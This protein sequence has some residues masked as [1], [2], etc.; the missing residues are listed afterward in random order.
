MRGFPKNF[1][2]KTDVYNSLAEFPKETKKEVQRLLDTR[3]VWVN[4]AVL[5]PAVDVGVVDDNH[6]IV[7][8]E[9]G[10]RIQYEKIE[11]INAELFRIGLTVEEAEEIING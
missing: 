2:T 9:D 7:D 11:D 8:G 3:F 5:D 6:K 1:G 10:E 4:G